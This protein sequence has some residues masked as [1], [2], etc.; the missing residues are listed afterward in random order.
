M[1]GKIGLNGF[2]GDG[3]PGTSANLFSPLDLEIAPDYS[4]L[5]ADSFNYVIRRWVDRT[6]PGCPAL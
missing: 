6:V 4:L 5:I 2:S 3:G 1:V